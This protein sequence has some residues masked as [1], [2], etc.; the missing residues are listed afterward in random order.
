M[1]LPQGGEGSD[2]GD[3]G[4]NATLTNRNCVMIKMVCTCAGPIVD[5]SYM[6]LSD[7]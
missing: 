7:T 6:W 2:S 4:Y 3:T 1:G 5:I